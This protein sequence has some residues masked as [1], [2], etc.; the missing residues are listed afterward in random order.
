[1][2][3]SGSIE[4]I[5]DKHVGNRQKIVKMWGIGLLETGLGWWN[6]SAKECRHLSNCIGCRRLLARL[7]FDPQPLQTARSRRFWLSHPNERG[8]WKARRLA[9]PK[10]GRSLPR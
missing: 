9:A 5:G 3:I 6:G 1:M 10:D 7:T 4:K 8:S 2:A